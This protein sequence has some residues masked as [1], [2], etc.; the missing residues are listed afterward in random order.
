MLCPQVMSAVSAVSCLNHKPMDGGEHNGMC[1]GYW[2]GFFGSLRL[3]MVLPVSIERL[4]RQPPVIFPIR[5]TFFGLTYKVPV[6]QIYAVQCV[7]GNLRISGS[8]SNDQGDHMHA[9]ATNAVMLWSR[10]ADCSQLD[11]ANFASNRRIDEGHKL[12]VKLCPSS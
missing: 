1:F 4:R 8:F 2:L 7:L 11:E 5:C 3:R 12:I 10:V 6:G 9:E